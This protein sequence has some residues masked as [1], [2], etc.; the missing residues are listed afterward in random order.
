[1]PTVITSCRERGARMKREDLADLMAFATIAKERSFTRAAAK[2]GLSSSALSHAM[3]LLEDRLG[4]KLLNRTT[5]SVAPTIAGERLLARLEPAL[6]EIDEGLNA[7]ADDRGHPRGHVRI[8]SHRSA[9]MLHVMPKLQQ[10]RSRYP[11]IVLELSTDDKMVDIVSAGFDAGIRDGKFVA[12]DMVAV[13]I[14]PPYRTAVVASPRYLDTRSKI[15]APQDLV[16]HHA[17]AYRFPSAGS[18]LRWQ[19]RQ[20]EHDFTVD[21]S[22]CFVSGL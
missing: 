10:L 13:R 18:M 12:K 3:R 14:G 7:L 16:Q 20:D 19:F 8:N 6:V 15:V 22:P 4:T 2:L 5:R 17:I 1:L 21:I 11:D 9:A